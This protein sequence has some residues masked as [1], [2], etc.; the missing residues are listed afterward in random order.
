MIK[1]I[2]LPHVFVLLTG[3]ILVCSI[4]TYIV[5]SGKYEREKKIIGSLTK[6]VV[7]PGTYQQME[8]HISPE[9]IIIGEKSEGKATPVSFFGFLSSIPRGMEAAA[10]IIFFIFIIGGVFGILQRTGTI[11]AFIQKLLDIF[12]HK[13]EVMV[14]ILMIVVAV[15]SSTLGMGEEFIPLIP[16]FLIVSKKLG[17]DRVFGLAIV[18]LAMEV[19]FSAATTNPFTVQIAQGIAEVPLNSGLELRLIFFF[20]T[21]TIAVIYLLRYGQKIKKDPSKSIMPDDDFSVD[22]FSFEKVDFKKEHL[23]IISIGALL[24][25]LIIFSVQEF[26]WWMSEMAGGFLLIG[27]AAIV[28][29]KIPINEAAK[30]FVKGMEEMLVA[31]M[32]VGFAKGVQ[33]VLEDGQ[34][35]DTIIFSAANTLQNFH[36]F[37]AAGGMLV[38]QT[39]L[40]FF[41]PSGS[42]QAAVTMPLMA[43]LSDLLGITRQTAVLAFTCGDG[44]SNMVIP[45][46]GLLMAVLS[47]AKIPY[48]K[49]VKFAFPLFLIMMF[50]SFA[51]LGIAVL[52][53]Y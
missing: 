4:F 18:M 49:W 9:S 47:I 11:M 35:L 22:H 34:I 44:F 13:A 46:S 15:G 38:F 8:K 27:V 25:A 17:Y 21:I 16:L 39:T 7:K 43:P 20:I 30:S 5:P 10:D 52:I 3:V 1:K 33:V 12:G 23:F 51:F 6:T 32:V 37:V 26:G 31:A 29:S 45:T 48:T 2:K 50:L 24:F 28:I 36:E 53:N 19:G 41:I 40:N 14:I 42:G